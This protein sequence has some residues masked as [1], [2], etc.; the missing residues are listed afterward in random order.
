MKTV[1]NQEISVKQAIWIHLGGSKCPSK[2]SASEGNSH[3]NQ[4]KALAMLSIAQQLKKP[5]HESHRR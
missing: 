2:L 4:C 1:Y 3:G 5:Q